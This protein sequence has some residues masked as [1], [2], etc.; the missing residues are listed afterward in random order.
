MKRFLRIAALPLVFAVAAL[1]ARHQSS[2]GHPV[3]STEKPRMPG[4]RPQMEK[5]A[6]P[7]D[8]TAILLA[9]EARMLAPNPPLPHKGYGGEAMDRVLVPYGPSTRVEIESAMDWA[10]NEP[11]KMFACLLGK[12]KRFVSQASILF[13]SWAESNVEAA[14]AGA[15]QIPDSTLRA[16][17]LLST[18]ESLAGTNPERARRLLLENSGLYTPD[19]VGD[20]RFGYPSPESSWEL[21][22][23]LPPGVERTRLEVLCLNYC[24]DEAAAALWNQAT[25][26]QHSEW[27]SAGFSPYPGASEAFNGLGEIMRTRAETTGNAA[28]AQEFIRVHGS[29][30]AAE[31]FEDATKWTMTYSKGETKRD[32][33]ESFYRT[34][35]QQDPARTIQVWKQLPEGYLKKNLAKT[36]L[37]NTPQE[38]QAE[39]EAAMNR[40]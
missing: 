21:V 3:A 7:G 4:T 25:E 11:E 40:K 8:T 5:P 24:E 22:Q 10:R 29:E 12:D 30:W 27:L 26:T 19:I 15:L 14:L 37:E 23:S 1:L 13:E 34:A 38:K 9:M 28:D 32:S 33:L 17:A 18:L 2:T 31:D 39:V 20:I 36:M 35:I 6:N 16:Q